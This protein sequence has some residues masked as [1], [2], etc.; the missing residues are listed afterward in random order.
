MYYLFTLMVLAHFISDF[1][2]QSDE[3][4][5]KKTFDTGWSMSF[6]VYHIGHGIFHLILWILA[7]LCFLYTIRLDVL[8]RILDLFYVGLMVTALHV[9]IDIC[10]QYLHVKFQKK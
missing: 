1:Y 5:K 3:M 2:L 10:T 6:F 8:P 4:V 9:L 7:G